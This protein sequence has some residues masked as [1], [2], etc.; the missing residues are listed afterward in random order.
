MN[1]KSFS[2]SQEFIENKDPF[3]LLQKFKNIV[4]SGIISSEE[5]EV[6]NNEILSRV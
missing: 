6:K 2:P 5:F 1:L 4:E 3:A